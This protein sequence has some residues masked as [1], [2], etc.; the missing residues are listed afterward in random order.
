[1]AEGKGTFVSF[2]QNYQYT[3]IF[4]VKINRRL[5]GGYETR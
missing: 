5:G 3:G 2:D 1:M 4:D